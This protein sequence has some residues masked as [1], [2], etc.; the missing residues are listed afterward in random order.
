MKQECDFIIPFN[1]DNRKTV[2]WEKCLYIPDS[3]SNHDASVIRWDDPSVFEKPQPIM[4]EFCSGNGQWIAHMAEQMPHLNWIAV[5]MDFERARKIWLKIFRNHLPNLFLAYGEGMT[6]AN[7]YVP[8]G[9]VREVYVNF[10]DP[11]P[12]RR[13]AKHRIVQPPFVQQIAR[14]LE[15]QGTATLVTDDIETSE[16][17]IDHFAA[18]KSRFGDQNFVNEWPEYYISYFHSLWL[19]KEKTI[20]Y[21]RFTHG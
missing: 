18:W 11:W 2:R 10:P 13:H 9:M 4:I 14:I 12:K 7:H 5:E 15:P 20:R 3:F 8:A 1:W 16:R 21:H 6:F 19:Q 17:F